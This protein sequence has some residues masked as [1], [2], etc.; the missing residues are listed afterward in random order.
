[1]RIETTRF[2][3][4]DVSVEKILTIEGG[5]IGFPKLTRFLLIDYEE[6]TPFKWLQA[7]DNPSYAFIVVDPRVIDSDIDLE[8]SSII[9]DRLGI[10]RKEDLAIL[11]VVTIP[12]NHWEMTVNMKGPLVFKIF[13]KIQ[14]ENNRAARS[15]AEDLK[16]A[17]DLWTKHRF[18]GAP[19]AD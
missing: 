14:E 10:S 17:A 18:E 16:K 3:V 5:L 19:D 6:E 2:G 13:D 7:I 11:V 1:M 8:I 12:D 15:G 9:G 4:I